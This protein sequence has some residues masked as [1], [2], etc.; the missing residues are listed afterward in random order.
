MGIFDIER[1]EFIDLSDK[2]LRFYGIF[3]KIPFFLD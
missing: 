2:P 3:E 1:V